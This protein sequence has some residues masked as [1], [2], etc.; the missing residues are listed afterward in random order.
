MSTDKRKNLDN[1]GY[2]LSFFVAFLWSGNPTSVKISLSYTTPFMVGFLRF[3]LGGIIALIWAIY[4]KQSLSVKKEHIFPIVLAGLLPAAQIGFY[5]IGQAHTLASHGIIMIV[6]F[7]LW[8]AIFS[9]F[10]TPNDRLNLSRSLGL[11]TAYSGVLVLFWDSI[12][13]NITEYLFGDILMLL[14]AM[15]LGGRLIWVSHITQK[16][17]QPQII[18]SEAVVGSL[19]S[20]FLSILFEKTFLNIS[21]SLILSMAYQGILIAGMGIILQ[22][23]LLSNYLPGKVT[24]FNLFQPIIGIFISWFLLGESLGF[25]LFLSITLLTIGT[26]FTIQKKV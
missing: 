3:T 5:N 16:V 19:M 23:Y 8:A 22:T 21:I 11:I 7:P 9:H 25:I 15:F 24:F 6:T 26:Y 14:S 20:I 2:F 18:I 17:G 10:F 12:N 13:Q 1:K 4:K